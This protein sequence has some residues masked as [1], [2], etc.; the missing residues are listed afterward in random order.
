MFFDGF[1]NMRGTKRAD[2]VSFIQHFYHMEKEDAEMVYDL[3]EDGFLR[4]TAVKIIK[5][6]KGYEIS[7]NDN[8]NI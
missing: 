2:N 8:I 3:M 6:L 1:I 5:E 4:P 7:E